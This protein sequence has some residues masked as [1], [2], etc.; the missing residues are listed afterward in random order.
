MN[1]NQ[2]LELL[3]S[4]NYP[5][6]SRDIVSFGMVDDVKIDG[7]TVNVTLKITTQQEEKITA[8]INDVTQTLEK[9]KAFTN[10]NVSVNKNAAPSNIGNVAQSPAQK[11]ASTL[12]GVKHVIAIASGKGG[13]GK[14]SIACNLAAMSAVSGKRTLV[15]DLDPQG[16]STNYLM[17]VEASELK[18]TIADFFEQ[19]LSFNL[20]NK[21]PSDY[22]HQSPFKNLHVLP[23]NPELDYLERKLEAKHK[24][25][26]LKNALRA[27]ESEFDEIFIDTSPIFNFYTRSALYGKQ[28]AASPSATCFAVT[29]CKFRVNVGRR[30]IHATTQAL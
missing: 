15:V 27:L 18:D 10:V 19:T 20:F 22:A 14:S 12:D 17:G 9:S 23:S 3:K 7:K 26:K 25:Y 16:N 2:I 6:F 1:N 11:P 21:D 5:G 29:H 30:D 24:I 28:W 8:V 13:V 4:V